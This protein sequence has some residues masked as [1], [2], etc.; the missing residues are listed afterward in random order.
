LA[1]GNIEAARAGHE[2]LAQ[3]AETLDSP[4]LRGVALRCRGA[5]LLAEGNA[6]DALA[7][8][9]KV[10]EHWSA[11]EVPYESAR[12]RLLSA[13][14]SKQ[15]GDEHTANSEFDAARHVLEQLGAAHD[16]K[17]LEVLSGSTPD[18]IP[19]GLSPRELEILT[20]VAKGKSNRDIASDLVISERT[21]ARHMSN[22]F[23]KLDV[24]SRT[25]ASAFAFEHDLV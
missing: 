12:L 3:I 4:L 15:A 23:N 10:W 6:T 8:F 18:E 7:T 5:V 11:L 2:E 22:I 1:A 16:F 24:A 20:L 25:A 19:G 9:A 13:Q 14:A 17:M 21:V